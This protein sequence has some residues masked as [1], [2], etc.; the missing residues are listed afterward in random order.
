VKAL[1][2]PMACTLTQVTNYTCSF[3]EKQ[4]NSVILSSQW[5]MLVVFI[6]CNIYCKMRN[7]YA[8]CKALI[9]WNFEGPN[10]KM[11]LEKTVKSFGQGSCSLA[12]IWTKHFSIYI[13][14]SCRD[15]G[16]TSL[17]NSGFSLQQFAHIV[18]DLHVTS[19][20]PVL[21]QSSLE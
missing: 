9:Q 20:L 2:L 3:T 18:L 10:F 14:V 7:L 6:L 15:P 1:P 4:W 16:F 21:F 5:S 19:M 13:I 8:Y 17:Y 12:M 11:I